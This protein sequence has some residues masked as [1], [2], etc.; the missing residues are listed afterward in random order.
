VLQFFERERFVD[1]QRADNSQPQPLMNQ[2]IYLVHALGR[3]AMH[4][5]QPLLLGLFLIWFAP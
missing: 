2:A 5:P 1:G 3:A 4:A